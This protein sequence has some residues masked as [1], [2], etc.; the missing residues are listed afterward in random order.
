[1]SRTRIKICGIT[2]PQD[3]EV[4]VQCG[5]DAI[6]MIFVPASRRYLADWGLVREIAQQAYPV[7][8]SV[9]L[10]FN[11]EVRQ[12]EAVLHQLPDAV[13]QFQGDEAAD[14]CRQ[15]GRPYIKGIRMAP[16][17]KVADCI[18]QHESASA[19]LFDSWKDG[20]SGGTG[21]VFDWQRLPSLPEGR[22]WF[23]AG[24]L[25][26]ANAAAALRLK[27]WG[28]DLASG[29]ESA[30]GIKDAVKMRQFFDEVSANGG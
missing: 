12:V 6:G 14:W 9:A 3:A 11:P 15:F 19:L 27:P 22:A 16:D 2:R 26:A 4:A 10:F 25:T 28:L 20:V 17:L 8:T 21:E 30:P 1:M 5:A 23:L 13:L 18:R 24:G 29:V 7:A